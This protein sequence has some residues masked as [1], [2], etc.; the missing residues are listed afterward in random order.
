MCFGAQGFGWF[1]V[2]EVRGFGDRVR[3]SGF[4]W[5]GVSGTGFHG[6][7]F[8]DSGFCRFGFRVRSFRYEVLQVRVPSTEFQVR[9]F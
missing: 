8:R 9:G 7:G 2:F 3:G 4:S 6:S 5:L 1:V